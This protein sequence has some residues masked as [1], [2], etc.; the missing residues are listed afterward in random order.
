V[1]KVKPATGNARSARITGVFGA[2]GTGKS[3]WTRQQLRTPRRNRLVIWSPKEREDGYAGAFDAPALTS[4]A[5]VYARMN[6]AGPTSPFR[7]VF[8]PALARKRAVVQF[9]A[10]CAAVLKLGNITLVVEELHTVTS[11]SWAPDQW[12]ALTLMGRSAGVEIFALSQ[13]PASV[14]KD[15]FSNCSMIHSGRVMY[16]DDAKVLGRVLLVPP[17][18][19][20]TLPDLHYIERTTSPSETRTGVVKV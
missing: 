13:R 6:A 2:T 14:D 8:V 19:L 20:L 7:L 1:T 5:D 3:I 9:D 11:A 10:L 15:L 18:E 16:E 4:M 17:S 12:S